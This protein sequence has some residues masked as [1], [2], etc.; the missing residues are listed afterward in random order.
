M[1]GGCISAVDNIL[2]RNILLSFVVETQISFVSRYQG[3][4]VRGISGSSVQF[5]WS[6]S[7]DVE[8]IDWGLTQAADAQGFDN[9]QTLFTEQ[10]WHKVS[11]T[12]APYSGR[13]S[14]SRRGGRAI[15]ILNNLQRG[16][17]RF[18]GCQINSPPDGGTDFDNVKL[19]V[20]DK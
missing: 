9:N 1:G 6:F 8:Y 14:G 4:T 5:N 11:N 2:F 7:G 10:V 16:D 12:P 19:V 17:T 3:S 20:E 15:F 13:V 18:Y